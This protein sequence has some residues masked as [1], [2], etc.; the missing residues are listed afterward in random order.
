M[1]VVVDV[2]HA[3]LTLTSAKER[4]WPPSSCRPAIARCCWR[5]SAPS[6]RGGDGRSASPRPV[7]RVAQLL[8]SEP[9]APAAAACLALAWR[10]R[11]ALLDG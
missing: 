5:S 7:E 4:P 11:E 9:L 1:F 10:D 2:I 8:G 6:W 3:S